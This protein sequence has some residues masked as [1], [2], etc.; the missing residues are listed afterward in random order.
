MIHYIIAF[1]L[2]L[3]AFHYGRYYQTEYMLEHNNAPSVQK[4][5]EKNCVKL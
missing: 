1:V 4:I 3:G 2:L 5:I